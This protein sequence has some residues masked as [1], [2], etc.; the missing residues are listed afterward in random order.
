[1]YHRLTD[2]YLACNK[3]EVVPGTMDGNCATGNPR[4]FVNI[5]EVKKIHKMGLSI[6]HRMPTVRTCL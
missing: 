1:M 6:K 4:E 5:N 2:I 3:G